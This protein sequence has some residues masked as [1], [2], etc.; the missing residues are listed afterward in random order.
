[1]HMVIY[2]LVE[3]SSEVEALA[4]AIE[5]FKPMTGRKREPGPIFDYFVTFDKD[6]TRVAGKARWGDLP[7]AA[8]I[9]SDEGQE[10]VKSG[11]KA[12]KNLIESNYSMTRVPLYNQ[13]GERIMNREQLD[14]LL[15]ESDGL[16]IVPADTHY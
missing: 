14:I 5:V 15:E 9:D 13:Q 16:W 1:M 7:I 3:A 8:P 12:T 4:K 10:L 11:W 2:A 6:D